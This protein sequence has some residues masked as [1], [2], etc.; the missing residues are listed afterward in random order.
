MNKPTGRKQQYG[1]S[2]VVRRIPQSL[3]DAIDKIGM[4]KILTAIA[5]IRKDEQDEV[6]R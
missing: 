5:K 1:E 4:T 2:T 6:Q 3:A